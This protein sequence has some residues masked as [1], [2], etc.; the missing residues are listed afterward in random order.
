MKKIKYF[1]ILCTGF[2]FAQE[3]NLKTDNHSFSLN[4]GIGHSIFTVNDY[5]KS[6]L[7]STTAT[8]LYD[9]HFNEN[10]SLEGGVGVINNSGNFTNAV[11]LTNAYL[12]IPITFKTNIAKVDK[13]KFYSG[14]G[15]IPSYKINSD[16]E[17]TIS[18]IDKEMLNDKGGN[19]LIGAKAGAE[20][21]ISSKIGLN[22]GFSMYYDVLQ[23]G[24]TNKQKFENITSI[25]IGLIV[26]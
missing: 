20:I 10:F 5:A 11:Y 1:L 7:N 14:V 22:V 3:D 2:L 21:P 13:S 6:N 15:I 26:F 17:G 16:L 12:N 24:Y 8:I 4:I 25:S 19:F 23:F 18:D 9:Y